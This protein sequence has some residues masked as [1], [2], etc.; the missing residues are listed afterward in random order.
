MEKVTLAKTPITTTRLGYGCA[1]L[2]RETSRR[3]RQD[4]L[5]A[6]YDRGIR[7]FDVARMYGLGAAEGEVG[8]FARGRRDRLVIATK[9]GIDPGPT[10]RVARLQ[11]PARALIAKYPWLRK[12]A[13]RNDGVLRS[14]RRY[15]AAIARTSLEQSLRELGT[16]YLD[17]FLIHDPSVGDEVAVDGLREF[18]E[19]ARESGTIRSWGVAG[20]AATAG[21]TA[22]AFG[23]ERVL[24]VRENIFSRSARRSHASPPA[25]ITFG[26]FSGALE[27]IVR[28]VGSTESIRRRWSETTGLD[29]SSTRIVAE[30]LVQDSV[31]ANEDGVV[32]FGTTKPGRIRVAA[33]ASEVETAPALPAFRQLVLSELGSRQGTVVGAA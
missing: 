21:A 19:N 6:A 7:H 17:L 1:G 32:L 2:M 23:L 31:G 25:Q 16:D 33:S 15:D 3:K 11:A 14:R 22:E 29:C 30:L 10:Q 5:A 12:V 18:L 28:H 27:Q 24:Q 9:F 26:V 20:E 8:R 13:R 4:L